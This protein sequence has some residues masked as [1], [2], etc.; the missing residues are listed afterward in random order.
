MLTVAHY[1]VG[2]MERLRGLSFPVADALRFAVG[3]LVP[4]GPA[5]AS[6]PEVAARGALRPFDLHIG[7]EHFPGLL[8]PEGVAQSLV[9]FASNKATRSLGTK[10]SWY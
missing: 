7:A 4:G 9:Q 2:L 3:G 1:G 8:A 6:F 10:P 5:L